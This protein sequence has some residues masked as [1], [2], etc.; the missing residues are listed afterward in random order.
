MGLW[1]RIK[2]AGSNLLHKNKLESDLDAEIREY[3]DAVAEEKIAAG[4][5]PSEARGIALAE[6]GG[7][8]QVKQAVRENRTGT[9]IELLWQD[10]RYGMR[11]LQR[12]PSFTWSAVITLGL[13]IGATTSIFSAV[14]SLLLRPLPYSKPDQLVSVTGQ[15]PK[16][17]SDVLV[18][19]DF[20]AAQHAVKSFS[21]LAGYWWANRNLTGS[22]D[23]V[24]IVWVG[25]TANL[26]PML[27][28]TP[29]LGRI[30]S[31]RE[32]G[33][34][35]PSMIILSNRIWRSQFQADPKVIGKSVTID[36]REETIIG[37]LP[38]NFSF[39]NY[40]LEPDVYAPADL[41]RDTSVSPEK[42]VL[43]IFTIGRLGPTIRAEQAQSEMQTFFEMRGRLP[44]WVRVSVEWA[45]SGGRIFA[46]TSGRRR[47]P[48]SL[49]TSCRSYRRSADSLLEC[50]QSPTGT[51]SII[52]A[53]NLCAWC[54]RR[55]PISAHP[56]ISG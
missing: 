11:M 17:Q 2:A 3:V 26:L 42:P 54:A 34:G 51:R 16:F 36:G 39:P 49:D 14:Y 12:N 47:S 22:G 6:I 30:F 28:V 10:V 20:V 5:S 25:A 27:G 31:E 8:E 53:R 33:P 46:E 13:G 19:P 9:S 44:S 43:G 7:L 40:G 48:A 29:Q 23:P 50:Y 18:S 38:A 55:L 41:D 4:M 15:S 24:R 37:V 52:P 45:P 1:L 32:D 56:Q 21:Q 35:G